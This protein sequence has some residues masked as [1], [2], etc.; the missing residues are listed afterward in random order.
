MAPRLDAAALV[1]IERVK[2]VKYRY[3]RCLDQKRWEE[4]GTCL[5]EDAVA[6]YSGGRYTFHGRAEILDFLERS[7]GRE[8]FHSSHRV[9][10]PEI[11]LT[12][13]ATALGVWALED[14]VIETALGI[15]IRGSAFYEDEYERRD[16]EWLITRTGY[17]RVFE[18]LQPRSS[19]PG[20]ELTASWW[21]TGGR[22]SLD[23]D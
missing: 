4:L 16:G 7:M 19:V 18:E 3:M 17:R 6:E 13:P 8:S 15:T 9:H 14:T 10:Q 21:S 20:L 22:S 5:A 11:D 2:R 1:E 12:G 23:A